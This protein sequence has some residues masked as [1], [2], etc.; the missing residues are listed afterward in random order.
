MKRTFEKIPTCAR[1]KLIATYCLALAFTFPCITSAQD[2]KE[3]ETPEQ[4]ASALR[5]AVVE[6]FGTPEQI[7]FFK[8]PHQNPGAKASL[9]SRSYS[10]M[11]PS[12]IFL[13]VF[14]TQMYLGLQGGG[15]S[16]RSSAAIQSIPKSRFFSLLRSVIG[17]APELP[18]M[19]SAVGAAQRQGE[20]VALAESHK[21]ELSRQGKFQ[22]ESAQALVTRI[23]SPAK[24]DEYKQGDY[25]EKAG[26]LFEAAYKVLDQQQLPNGYVVW[27]CDTRGMGGRSGDGAREEMIE[28]FPSDPKFRES[29]WDSLTQT[30]KWQAVTDALKGFFQS[31]ADSLQDPKKATSFLSNLPQTSRGPGRDRVLESLGPDAAAIYDKSEGSQKLVL[32]QSANAVK[33]AFQFVLPMLIGDAQLPDAADTSN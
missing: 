23:L 25:A 7:E 32:E 2:I 14:S 18:Y 19:D 33:A 21:E 11:E 20:K 12:D 15:P 31:G 6:N 1:S 17:S 22:M 29:M 30:Q 4:R 16:Q 3:L 27:L 26:L 10:Q 8:H 9:L 13:I 5:S 28:V 24:S